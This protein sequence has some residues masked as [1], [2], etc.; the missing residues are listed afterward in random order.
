MELLRGDQTLSISNEDGLLCPR[1]GM[2]GLMCTCQNKSV[3][4]R[5]Q[6]QLFNPL[7]KHVSLSIAFPTVSIGS[8]LSDAE[9]LVVYMA[10]NN[11]STADNHAGVG[12]QSLEE[13]TWTELVSPLLTPSGHA[14]YVGP[15][16]ELHPLTQMWTCNDTVGPLRGLAETLALRGS[17]NT[18]PIVGSP[19]ELLDEVPTT[20][21]TDVGSPLAV[22]FHQTLW[23]GLPQVPAAY[24]TVEMSSSL[25]WSTPEPEEDCFPATIATLDE[26]SGVFPRGNCTLISEELWGAW[27]LGAPD[28]IEAEGESNSS[29][30]ISLQVLDWRSLDI[31][32]WVLEP[33]G[34]VISSKPWSE[35]TQTANVQAYLGSVGEDF[36]DWEV[37]T[38]L[39]S[40]NV[41][42]SGSSSADVATT[43]LMG[44]HN[45]VVAT[46][47]AASDPEQFKR[48]DIIATFSNSA[49]VVIKMEPCA[50][51]LPNGG[52]AQGS[53]MRIGD[54]QAPAIAYEVMFLG[55]AFWVVTRVYFTGDHVPIKLL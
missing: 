2:H 26:A 50:T 29:I 5:V 9:S 51:P 31:E 1:T 53:S 47:L 12:T 27:M 21:A 28:G 8:G 37:T 15:T 34:A 17:Y 23:T 22:V 43:F 19:N 45:P 11:C 14:R 24:A 7:R 30:H 39:Q 42:Q 54:F 6:P 33:A 38:A 44:T 18:L 55:Y 49:L 46:S 16:A 32:V 10:A 41:T 20:V 13:E 48:N 52:A 36:E 3:K 40:S 25:L 4:L 35:F